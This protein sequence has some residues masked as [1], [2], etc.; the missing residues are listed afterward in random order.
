MPK[1]VHTYS[2]FQLREAVSD[3]FS[4]AETLRKLGIEASGGNYATINSR[5]KRF[6]IDISHFTGMLWSK[7]KTIGPKRDTNDYLSNKIR[8]NT[9][10]L[11]LRLIKEGVF[12]HKCYSCGLTTWQNTPIPIELHH[13][14]GNNKNN[15]LDNLQILCPN[16]HAQTDNYCSKKT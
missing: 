7:G 11:K 5:I 4:L 3:S 10:S 13:I 6:N 12:N 2:E 15:S 9:H 14:D 8:I 1:R 16:C